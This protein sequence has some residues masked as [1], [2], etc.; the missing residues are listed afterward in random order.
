MTKVIS[1]VGKSNSGKTTLLEKIVKELTRRGYSIGTI[2]HDT[3]GFEIDYPGKD[4]YRHFH[5]GSQMTLISGPNQIALVKRLDKPLA[6]D[7][8]IKLFFKPH[9]L[10]LIIT[11]GFK[12][13][14]KPKIEI[15]RKAVS[16][17]PICRTKGDLLV[18]L[19]SDTKIKDYSVPQFGLNEIKKIVNFIESKWL[20]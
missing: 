2:K 10:D 16:T 8:T 1:L 7:A 9:K 17:E 19:V 3:H 18:A 6:L 14:N 15:V 13:E 5:A 4:S 11:E 20:V 12:R